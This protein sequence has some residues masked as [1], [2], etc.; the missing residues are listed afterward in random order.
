MTTHTLLRI[1]L[2]LLQ[3]WGVGGVDNAWS[4]VGQQVLVDPR[5]ELSGGGHAAYLPMTSLAGSLRRHLGPLA[6]HWLGGRPG[7]L[8]ASTGTLELAASKL[9]LLGAVGLDDTAVSSRGVTA[10]DPRRGAAQGNMLRR[11]AWTDPVDLVVIGSHAGPADTELLDKLADWHPFVGRGRGKGQG[12]AVV[13][14]VEALTVDLTQPAHLT[15]WLSERDGWLRGPAAAPAFA[16]PITRAGK[17]DVPAPLTIEWVVDEPVHVGSGDVDGDI[18]AG[19]VATMVRSRRRSFVPGSSWKGAFRHRVEAVL[20]VAD[21]DSEAVTGVC[22][23][24]FGSVDMGRGLLWFGD[25]TAARDTTITRTHV[26]IDRFTGGV[27]DGALFQVEG[28]PR[29]ERL[30]LTI[31]TPAGTLPA[32]VDNLVRHVV[33]DIHDGLVGIGGNGSRGYGS[34]RL[35]KPEA[36]TTPQPLDLAGLLSA[37]GVQP[38]ST[39]DPHD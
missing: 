37:L 35:A 21:A 39:G 30:T 38:D 6:E 36:L 9:A 19:G 1:H 18:G 23:R 7:P 5:R 17:T 28:M 25:S 10:G 15:W 3:R 33:R 26:A 4:Q 8:E 16:A 29:G 12:Q 14:L 13:S 22:E 27:R 32:P 34:L 11:E 31:S 24:L 2:S 20:A